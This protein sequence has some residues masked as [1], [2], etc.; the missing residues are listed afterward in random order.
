MTKADRY[1]RIGIPRIST[2][3]GQPWRGFT[4]QKG[5]AFGKDKLG[6]YVS[7]AEQAGS[8][9]FIYVYRC[10]TSSGEYMWRKTREAITTRTSQAIIAAIRQ[11]GR[12]LSFG[13]L[14]KQV[15]AI[16]NPLLTTSLYL[17][18]PHMRIPG[19]AWK[20]KQTIGFKGQ[21]IRK[22]DQQ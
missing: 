4:L 2:Y 20:P 8:R 11:Y 14:R 17:P 1:A 16:Y 10:D 13:P 6:F 22:E 12:G 18:M 19:G 15:K 9:H 21:I 3:A 7:A 5:H